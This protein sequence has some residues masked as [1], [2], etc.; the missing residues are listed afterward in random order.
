MTAKGQARN[1]YPGLRAF[2]F[3]QEVT[4]DVA[5][6]SI[7]LTDERAPGTAELVLTNK[8]TQ[9]QGRDDELQNDR[10]VI[11]NQDVFAMYSS[12]D[13][14]VLNLPDTQTVL[15]DLS[16][17]IR[18]ARTA[19]A[20]ALAFAEAQKSRGAQTFD[21]EGDA[22]DAAVVAESAQA[23]KSVIV[24]EQREVILQES[25]TTVEN[26]NRR[27]L[28]R[29]R[30]A[31]ADPVKQAVI[32]AKV[33]ARTKLGVPDERAGGTTYI[34]TVKEL[35]ALRGEALRYPFQVGDSIFHSQ[36]PVRIFLRDPRNPKVWYHA[37]AGFVSDTVDDV[38]ENN[39]RV[40][41]IRC[42][43]V[44]RRLRYARFSTSPGIIDVD[45]ALTNADL[46]IRTFYN[47][48]FDKLN[49]VEFL[50]SMIFGFNASDTARQAGIVASK[51]GLT[52]TRTVELRSANG[53]KA[54]IDVNVDGVG[55]FTFKKS[56]V[57]I[58]GPRGENVEISSLANIAERKVPIN[59]LSS[60]QAIIDH[61]VRASDLEG[62][63]VPAKG[64]PPAISRGGMLKNENG[65]P[66]VD[67]VIKAIGE[68]P[69]IYPV[70]GGR[71]FMLLPS[72]VGV[73]QSADIF[74]LGF[75]GP[76]LK[77]S[78]TTRLAKIYDVLE[79]LQMSFW[80][81]PKGDVVA[82][83]PLCDF[84][85][86][87]FGEETVTRGD[88]LQLFAD[89][90]L[91]SSG[92]GGFFLPDLFSSGRSVSDTR[93]PYAPVFNIARRDTIR[94]S[95]SFNDENVRTLA[96]CTWHPLARAI[97]DAGFALEVAG[98]KPARRFLAA[99]V[100]QFGVRFEEV[101]PTVLTV[102]EGAAELL[103]Q[104]TLNRINGNARSFD[105]KALPQIQLLPNRPVLFAE[106]NSMSCIRSVTQSLTWGQSGNMDMSLKTN[107]VRAWDGLVDDAG[108]LYYTY[109]GGFAANPL[110]YAL[111][112]LKQ[113][114]PTSNAQFEGIPDLES[115]E[116]EAGA[117]A[118]VA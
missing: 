13:P 60:Y 40:V 84:D 10:Y 54:E 48:D 62:M 85:P 80:A 15:D 69:H 51:R 17:E 12:L 41:T 11:T 45:A 100:P 108:R 44:L 65:E 5:S 109:L 19:E 76:E 47:D 82:E 61:Q 73:G 95:R 1:F 36:D 9:A 83:I 20:A 97:S 105:I 31:I 106:R 72:T 91:A 14:E 89:K 68:N 2:I 98:Q 71:V 110:N 96:T 118:V 74:V 102:D 113:T 26:I 92:E 43:D 22:Y 64:A 23:M 38:D 86:V 18:E 24:A 33:A 117:G 50:F 63:T 42:E 6:L 104:L 59:N 115:T 32:A 3:G 101:A 25:A 90:K 4:A 55:L 70:D 87:D 8:G 111:L 67:E 29:I 79:R 35:A 57:F 7:T 94:W 77:T 93:G 21:A 56:A 99:L 39:Q 107:Y 81:T 30:R 46:A 116:P 103:C 28:Q 66:K 58:I 78:A 16:R 114:P 88:L 49:I 53:G 75:K 37:F 112:F 27:L 34:K 52:G